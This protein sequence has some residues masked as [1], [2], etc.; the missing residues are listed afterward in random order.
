M[1][2][3]LVGE[4][5]IHHGVHIKGVDSF[6][7]SGYGE[8]IQWIKAA[9]EKG[10]HRFD[11][12]PSHLAIDRFPDLEQLSS[13]DVLI[14]SDV[15]SNT[16]LLPTE[17]MVH[18]K[19]APNRL[20]T[21]KRYVFEGGGFAMIG[22]YMTFMGIDGRARYKGTPVEEVLPVL[23]HS[24]DD[25]VETPQGIVP[26]V[27]DASHPVVSG[28]EKEWPHVLG[29]NRV[30][31]KEDARLLVALPN[32]D[33]LVVVGQAGRGR[34][35][36]FTTDCAPHWAPPEFLEWPGYAQFWDQAIRWLGAEKA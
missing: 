33:P 29:Y 36:A 18:S 6:V 26:T 5:W 32:G 13:Y 21:I 17:T 9:L 35:M 10:G 28:L 24:G 19:T 14:I 25:R 22:G 8:G 12:L 34:S 7:Q 31:P 3:L 11:H 4:T 23:L 2:V 16:L 27:V 1:R 20:E 30:T 15:G